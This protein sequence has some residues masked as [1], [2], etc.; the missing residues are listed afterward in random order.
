MYDSRLAPPKK[1]FIDFGFGWL[2]VFQKTIFSST[3]TIGLSEAQSIGLPT[4]TEGKASIYVC[5][6]IKNL[7]WT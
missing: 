3:V 2:D 6:K 7:T 1:Q 4:E 5:S